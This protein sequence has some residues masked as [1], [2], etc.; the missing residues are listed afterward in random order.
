MDSK[1]VEKAGRKNEK[2][3]SGQRDRTKGDEKNRK[4]SKGTIICAILLVISLVA[5]VVLYENNNALRTRNEE[6]HSEFDDV[7]SE[8]DEVKMFLGLSGL[9]LAESHQKLA[10]ISSE[11]DNYVVTRG[12]IPYMFETS[13]K[14][15]NK[16]VEGFF[17]GDDPEKGVDAEAI[18]IHLGLTEDFLGYEYNSLEEYEDAF[19]GKYVTVICCKATDIYPVI[20]IS[21]GIAY[22]I[23]LNHLWHL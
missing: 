7:W 13:D 12:A 6:L 8:L 23:N 4:I 16:V 9:V 17:V 20:I 3:Q 19:R 1:D 5:V 2:K 18:T 11:S 14:F 22:D 10:D 15:G 21:D